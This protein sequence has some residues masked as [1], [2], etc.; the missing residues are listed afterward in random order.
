MPDR[1]NTTP[2]YSSEHTHSTSFKRQLEPLKAMNMTREKKGRQTDRQTDRT[3]ETLPS[4]RSTNRCLSTHP[5]VHRCHLFSVH[6][7][8][9]L[10]APSSPVSHLSPLW[11]PVGPWGG[12]ALSTGRRWPAR[13]RDTWAGRGSWRSSGARPRWTGLRGCVPVPTPPGAGTGPSG[14]SSRSAVAGRSSGEGG[15]APLPRSASWRGRRT[16]PLHSGGDRYTGK[17]I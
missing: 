2:T 10:S 4:I 12:E 9:T 5:S 7:L 6:S 13:T 3:R 11:S 1:T 8:F 17:E 16:S 14:R 15:T